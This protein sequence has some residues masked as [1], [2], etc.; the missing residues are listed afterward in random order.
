MAVDRLY[1][2]SYYDPIENEKGWL[3]GWYEW[4]KTTYNFQAYQL[5]VGID[6]KDAHAYDIQDMA[7]FAA[8]H[9]F[10][11]GYWEF[12]PAREADSNASTEAILNAY[13]ANA[14]Q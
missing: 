5:S 12:D 10:S 8:Q 14:P 3:L 13:Q 2:M 6:D 9:G 11:T 7:A 1:V 4:L